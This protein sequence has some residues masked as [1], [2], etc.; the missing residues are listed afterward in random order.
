MQSRFAG[1]ILPVPLHNIGKVQCGAD[2]DT[3]R[4][5][6]LLCK[7]FDVTH[8]RKVKQVTNVRFLLILVLAIQP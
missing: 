4:S 3:T 1:T 6:D 8:E 2:C 5:G 7:L